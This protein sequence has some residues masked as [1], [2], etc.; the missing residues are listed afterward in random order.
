MLIS[1]AN[2]MIMRSKVGGWYILAVPLFGTLRT[3]DGKFEISLVDIVQLCLRGKR[4]GG[5]QL[6]LSENVKNL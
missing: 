4:E 1:M 6:R 2:Y 5:A 3:E